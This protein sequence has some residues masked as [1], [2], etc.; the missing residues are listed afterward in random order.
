[1]R[2]H[3]IHAFTEIRVGA[4][5]PSPKNSAKESDG[6]G[7]NNGNGDGGDDGGK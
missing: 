6:G 5:S 3:T 7:D 4:D 1:M 2:I